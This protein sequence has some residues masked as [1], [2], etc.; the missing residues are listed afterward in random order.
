MCVWCVVLYGVWCCMVC[1]VV[2]CVVLYGVVCCVMLCSVVAN[3]RREQSRP[4]PGLLWHIL[5]PHMPAILFV[6]PPSPPL[7]LRLRA[8]LI[9]C[10]SKEP[11]HKTRHGYK[12][13]HT[14]VLYGAP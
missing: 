9:V 2:W 3:L 11:A 6:W 12:T 4:P 8:L 5:L 13:R 1:G 10:E 7:L 14:A